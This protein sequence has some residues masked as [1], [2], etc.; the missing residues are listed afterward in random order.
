MASNDD[1][2]QPVEPQGLALAIVVT[3]TIFIALTTVVVAMRSWV[4]FRMKNAGVDDLAMIAGY[5]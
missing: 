2:W 1:L 5:V 4:R 3:G